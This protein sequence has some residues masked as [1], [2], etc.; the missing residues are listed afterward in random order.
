MVALAAETG[1]PQIS[2]SHAVSPLMKLVARGDTV[3]VW[4]PFT[5]VQAIMVT[6]KGIVG[7]ADTR[8]RGALAVGH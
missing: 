7:A 6:P 8:T 5:A 1:F 3:R 4:P 2:V